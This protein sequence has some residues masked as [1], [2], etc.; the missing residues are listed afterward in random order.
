VVCLE[1]LEPSEIDMVDDKMR[2]NWCEKVIA[3][4]AS[5]ES[6]M[7]NLKD[8]KY[9]IDE[10]VFS[11]LERCR[12]GYNNLQIHRLVHPYIAIHSLISVC[13]LESFVCRPDLY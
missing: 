2:K 7:G 9:G 5:A 12:Y 13:W 11:L 10:K 8:I 4:R 1:S 6:I 3:T